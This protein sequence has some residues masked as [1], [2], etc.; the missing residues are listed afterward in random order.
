MGWETYARSKIPLKLL[1]IM[2]VA[3]VVNFGLVIGFQALV[4]YR[5]DFPVDD[6]S[7]LGKMDERYENCTLVDIAFADPN[8]YS[9]HS[10][11][12][13]IIFLV[14]TPS[15]DFELVTVARHFLFDRYRI[16]KSACASLE[17]GTERLQLRSGTTILGLNVEKKESTGLPDISIG[18]IAGVAGKHKN[19]A[20]VI[21]AL[22]IA[23]Y[24]AY[25]LLF[26]R[27][28]LVL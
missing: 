18:S 1:A 28:E 17:D 16:V 26:K 10:D 9:G 22:C 13:E 19:I 2:I 24:V 12:P 3:V 11:F 20:I 5:Y 27:E 7:V 4:T 8:Y 23:E 15:G 21:A 25:C 6:I 14:E